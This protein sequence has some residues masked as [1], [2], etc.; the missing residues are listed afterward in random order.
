[1]RRFEHHRIADVLAFRRTHVARGRD[2]PAAVGRV[3]EQRGENR[4][5][6][7]AR[8]A[9]PIDRPVATDERGRAAIADQRVVFDAQ[10]GY[11][12]AVT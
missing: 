5:V 12:A 11:F 4:I 2:A 9:Q 1:V 6:I 10:R 7:E 8:Q 3:T